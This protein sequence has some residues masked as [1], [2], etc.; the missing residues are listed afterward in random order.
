MTAISSS[1]PSVGL[2]DGPWVAYYGDDFTGSTDVM[3]AFTAAG[4]PTVLFLQTPEA[5]SLARFSHMRCVGLAGTSRGRDPAWMR[6][7]LPS[8]FAS[9]RQLGAPILQYKVCSTFDSAPHVGSIGQAIDL[10]VQGLSAHWSPTIVG[11]PRLQRFQ[12]FGQLFAGFMGEVYRIDRHPSM[13]RHPVTP[14]DEADLRVHLGR[15]TQRRIE[16]IDGVQSTSGQGDARLQAVQGEDV[17]VVMLDVMDSDSQREA[18]RLVWDNRGSGLFSASSSGLQY[19]LVAY[20]RSRGWLPEQAALPVATPASAIAVVSGSCSVMSGKQIEWALANGFHGERLDVAA[21]LQPSTR[22]SEIERVVAGSLQALAQGRS[23]VVYSAMGPDDAAVSG[24]EALVQSSGL[25]RGQ[26]AEA[27]GDALAEVMKQLLD[28]SNLR[29]VVVAG[30][31][32]SGA[33]ASHLGV[34]ALTVS[35]GLR[36]GAPLCRAWSTDARRDGLELVLKGGQ[37]GTP[38]FYGEVLSGQPIA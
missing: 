10:G 8:A 7:H 27:I 32:S 17:P 1:A 5:S 2:P 37:M 4:V 36:P 12:V 22:V 38:S 15:Q 28:R 30:G 14:M 29:R 34:Q 16:L 25:A 23:T 21:C 31:D 6:E 18:G 20:W 9:L 13:S 35:A 11:A 19:A 33:V 24:F 3:E 26:A